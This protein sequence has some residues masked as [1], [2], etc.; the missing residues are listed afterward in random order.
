MAQ[1]PIS[2]HLPPD[3]KPTKA[4][5]AYGHRAL[6]KLNEELRSEDLTTRQKALMALCDLMHDPEYVYQAIDIGCLE[7]LKALLKDIND[8]VRIKATEVLY[9][10]AIHTM[11][12]SSDGKEE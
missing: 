12:R 10:M 1:A 11:G 2:T 6:P 9:I 8:L 7:S 3:T 5:I 4:S